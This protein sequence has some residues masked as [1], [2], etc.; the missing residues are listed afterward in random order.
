MAYLV[1][2]LAAFV[3]LMFT[4][5]PALYTWFNVE[6]ANITPLWTIGAGVR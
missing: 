3:L 6:P 5:I 2:C 1:V 4:S